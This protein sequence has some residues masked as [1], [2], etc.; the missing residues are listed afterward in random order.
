MTPNSYHQRQVAGL[1]W[2]QR[3]AHVCRQ[4]GR[5]EWHRLAWRVFFTMM[6]RYDAAIWPARGGYHDFVTVAHGRFDSIE[7]AIE[8]LASS[9]AVAA[10]LTEEDPRLEPGLFDVDVHGETWMEGWPEEAV[11][12]VIGP[13]EGEEGYDVPEYPLVAVW[14]RE[15]VSVYRCRDGNQ[16]TGCAHTDEDAAA[17][18][19]K[20]TAYSEY[21]IE[22]LG[23]K[24]QDM[25]FYGMTLKG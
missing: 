3:P 4:W 22:Y 20:G 16:E 21:V 19:A 14:S 11:V 12:S 13:D 5:Y 9:D 6:K 15:L 24:A 8:T 25:G 17:E 23:G 2:A 7:E 10:A 1:Q 18:C